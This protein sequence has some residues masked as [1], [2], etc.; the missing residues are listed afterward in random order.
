MAK[1]A[2][3]AGAPEA[4]VPIPDVSDWTKERVSQASLHLEALDRRLAVIGEPDLHPWRGSTLTSAGTEVR[5][6]TTW[7]LEQLTLALARLREDTAI[8]S[9]SLG[10]PPPA[11]CATRAPE[12]PPPPRSSR[13]P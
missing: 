5:Q 1:V 3:L 11:P 9:S 12:P 13:R 4:P 6:R 10:A 8:L 2:R 7:L